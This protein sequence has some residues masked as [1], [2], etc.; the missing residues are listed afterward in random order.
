MSTTSK[1]PRA[2]LATAHDVAKAALPAYSHVNSPKKFTQHQLFACLVLKA[3]MK[4][5]YRGLQALLIDCAD[6]RDAVG[7][8]AVPHWTA[9]QKAA[10]RLLHA[11]A[12]ARLL[13]ATVAGG[14]ASTPQGAVDS[15]GMATHHASSY[16]TRRRRDTGADGPRT[17]YRHFPKLG[18]LCDGATH[19]VLACVSKRGPAPDVVEF[20]PLLRQVHARRRM[21]W[22]VA[23]AGYD[24]EPNHRVA[25]DELGI[26]T[27][28][29]PTRGRPTLDGKPPAGRY[30]RLMASR[31][32]RDR[33]GQRW[34]VEL[35]L[36]ALKTHMRMEM[37]RTKSPELAR[38]EI[39]MHFLAYN[40]IRG[41]MSEA[42]RVEQV[43]PRSLSFVRSVHTVRA[44]EESH[45]Y[46]PPWIA[47]DLPRLLELIGAKRLRNRPDR[48]EPRAVKRRPKPHPLLRMP[49][50]KARRLIERGQHI[51]NKA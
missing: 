51:Y 28:I 50:K 17:R 3:S 11:A 19:Q 26:R 30:R 8:K 34:Q 41:L 44:F 40:L 47:A 15:T 35:D 1:S 5:D 46:D 36:R 33:Y 2:I 14:P 10:A 48:Y 18:L 12:V 38:K 31:M 39:A 49:R 23:D 6:L 24:S 45:L 4:L 42:A 21:E 7:L 13:D 37:L 22:V 20:A 29:P 32:D 43:K 27:A 9:F 25:R 16:Y